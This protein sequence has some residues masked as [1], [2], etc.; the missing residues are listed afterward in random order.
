MSSYLKDHNNV[1]QVDLSMEAVLKLTPLEQVEYIIPEP[2]PATILSDISTKL[3]PFLDTLH[4]KPGM[5]SFL[6]TANTGAADNRHGRS[7]YT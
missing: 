6:T 1:T 7:V 4:L 5:F 3:V 2:S